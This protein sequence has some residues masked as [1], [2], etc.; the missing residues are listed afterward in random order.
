MAILASL[1]KRVKAVLKRGSLADAPDVSVQLRDAVANQTGA[2]ASELARRLAAKEITLKQF[3]A[4]LFL[5]TRNAHISQFA[6]ARGGIGAM[7]DADRATLGRLIG[8][9][10]TYLRDF[11]AEIGKGEMTAEEIA[12]RAT[13]YPESAIEAHSRGQMAAANLSPPNVPPAHPSCRCFIRQAV[14]D[15]APVVYWQ[16]LPGACPICLGIASGMNPWR[17]EA[18]A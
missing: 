18:A 8:D 6:L 2:D 4:E 15:D 7:T 17:P 10:A 1:V 12:R 16:T 9:Q 5:M 14:E 13:M 11:V 3:Q